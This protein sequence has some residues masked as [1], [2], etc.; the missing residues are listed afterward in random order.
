[1]DG[2]DGRRGVELVLGGRLDSSDG[3]LAFR[4]VLSMFAVSQSQT[5]E[6]EK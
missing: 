3:S 2:R 6:M 4:V 1:M 5:V